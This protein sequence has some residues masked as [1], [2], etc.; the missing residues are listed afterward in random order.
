M[1]WDVSGFKMIYWFFKGTHW[2]NGVKNFKKELLEQNKSNYLKSQILQFLPILSGFVSKTNFLKTLKLTFN[3]RHVLDVLQEQIT[4]LHTVSILR[5]RIIHYNS[6]LYKYV[7]LS[8]FFVLN[9]Y[10]TK[11]FL[12]KIQTK[13]IYLSK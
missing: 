6:K 3:F 11:A 2:I 8:L 13:I 7:D 1:T 5:Q 9:I 4:V 12:V 10:I